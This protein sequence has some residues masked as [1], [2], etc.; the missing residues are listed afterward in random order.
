M[1]EEAKAE[2]ADPAVTTK[3]ATPEGEGGRDDAFK[4]AFA[5][6]RKW[7]V[8][9]IDRHASTPFSSESLLI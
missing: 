5:E 1:A 4:A 3:E 7:W 6:L 8:F 9:G 2:G